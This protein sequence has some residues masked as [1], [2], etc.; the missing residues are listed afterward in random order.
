MHSGDSFPPEG[1]L[2][3]PETS[4]ANNLDVANAV[5]VG[6][7]LMKTP[8]RL[9]SS[10][11]R[12]ALCSTAGILLETNRALDDVTVWNLATSF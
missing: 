5:R 1:K 10:E 9:T 11:G 3:Q 6:H 12:V 7:E 2:S 8:H 4:S